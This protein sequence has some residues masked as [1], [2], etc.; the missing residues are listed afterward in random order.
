MEIDKLENW[1]RET[2]EF[3][4]FCHGLDNEEDQKVYRS[5]QGNDENTFFTFRVETKKFYQEGRRYQIFYLTQEM[6][7]HLSEDAI[8]KLLSDWMREAIVILI[9]NKVITERP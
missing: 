6:V 7:S 4:I 2:D 1:Y 8:I 5:L 9:A 3:N